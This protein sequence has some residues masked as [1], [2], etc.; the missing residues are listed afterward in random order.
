MTSVKVVYLK[1]KLVTPV[2][3]VYLLYCLF[4]IIF[5]IYINSVLKE[6]KIDMKNHKSK[7]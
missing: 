7:A 4:S 3:F 6:E 5:F 1:K 2:E